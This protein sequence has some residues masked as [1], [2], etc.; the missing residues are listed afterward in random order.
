MRCSFRWQLHTAA[1]VSLAG[2]NFALQLSL[3]ASHRRYGVP[4][5]AACVNC[6]LRST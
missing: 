6:S 5:E 1:T 2:S 4:P 3:A